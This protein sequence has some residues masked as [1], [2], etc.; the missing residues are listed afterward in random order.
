[1]VVNHFG[2]S[3]GSGACDTGLLGRMWRTDNRS[4]FAMFHKNGTI[5]GD[6]AKYLRSA[7]H[8]IGH[9]FN[10]HHEDGDG[11]TTIMN[12]TGVVGDS[13]VFEFSDNSE[14]H[15]EDHPDDCSFPGVGTFGSVNAEH[16]GWHGSVTATCS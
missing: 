7:A 8:E 6:G 10:L 2:R 15:L 1:V 13:F 9:A 5:Q 16:A 4:A 11:S 3:G 14:T 12:Q